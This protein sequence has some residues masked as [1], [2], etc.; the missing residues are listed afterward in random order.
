MQQGGYGGFGGM[1][2]AGALLGSGVAGLNMPNPANNAMQYYNQIP[3]ILNATY[4]PYMA[5]GQNAGNQLQ[6]Q[7]GNLLNNPGG[8][9]NSIG[10]GFQGSPQYAWQVQQATLGANNAAAAG[11]MAGSPAEQQSLASTIGGLAN[12]NYQQ[13]I[14][15]AMGAYGLGMNSANNIYGIGANAA[16]EYG[17]NMAQT[18]SG[19]GQTAYAGQVNQNETQGGA[20]GGILG[21]LAGILGGGGSGS[22]S[23]GGLLSKYL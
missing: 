3:S 18:L 4:S 22:N 7:I 20:W 8:F 5:Q 17:S 12:Q 11:G 21:G 10:Q 9:I 6:G 16:N 23:F 2:G 1:M 13:Y 19:Q 14:Q 15:N